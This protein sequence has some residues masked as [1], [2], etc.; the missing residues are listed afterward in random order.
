MK[1]WRRP[2]LLVLLLGGLVAG[3]TTSGVG[4]R[5]FPVRQGE[6]TLLVSGNI[7]AHESVVGFKAVQSRIVELPYDE[8]QWVDAGT[9]L[10]RLD[11][12]DYRQQ[13]AIDRAA[14]RAR[15]A[16]HASA[17]Q[18]VEAAHKTVLADEAEYAQRA[19]DLR[20]RAALLRASVVSREE[21]DRAE[22]A[23]K[24]SDAVLQRD[25]ALVAV[26]ERDVEVA[27]AG[28]G[29]AREQIRMARIIL[30]YT[31]LHAPF[32]GVVLVR[33]AELGE[34]MAP[35]T[36]V[37]TLADLGHVWLRA[38]VRETDLGRIRWGQAVTIHTDTYPERRYPGRISFI[39][40]KAE[41]TPKSVETHAERVT[42]VYRIRIDVDNPEQELKPGMPAD[43][44]IE[45]APKVG[46][47]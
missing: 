33:H 38:Y 23:L 28:T 10:A 27:R 45:L 11:A 34:V 41:F 46:N 3:A 4:A 40:S 42:L 14:L 26:R 9:L 32:A 39:S 6:A 30:G 24:Q 21:L 29:S 25:R 37:V 47:G 1:R 44:A 15:V 12:T 22:T 20:R 7:E 31:E 18:A 5:L 8:G 43:A 35:G 13:L 16:E 19:L 36:P 2:W 17:E